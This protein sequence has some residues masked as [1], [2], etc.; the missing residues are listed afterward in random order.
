VVVTF[1]SDDTLVLKDVLLSDITPVQ[2]RFGAEA[3]AASAIPA[4]PAAPEPPL[5]PA[6]E[7][8][9]TETAD[10]I[11][12]TTAADAIHA[13]AGADVLDGGRGNDLLFGEDGTDVL[14]GGAGADTL[15]GGEGKDDFRD[16]AA[17]LNGD[18][19]ADFAVGDRIVITD[20]SL[21]GF[22]FSLSGNTLSFTGGSLTLANLAAGRSSRASVQAAESSLS[23]DRTTH[24]AT[25][26]AI[27]G[28]TSCGA[29]PAASSPTGSPIRP[30]ASPPMALTPTPKS[31]SNG[32]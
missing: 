7:Q 9:G 13:G 21:A 22:T 19:I 15:T 31:R 25:S 1:A 32:T 16:T 27:A 29:I 4:Q 30:A 28:A 14:I 26:T 23:S 3:I 10:I 6:I 17:G 5:A 8:H 24:V 2:F 11:A 20:A 12:G 18:T